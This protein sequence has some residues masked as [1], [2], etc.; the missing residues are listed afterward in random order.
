[1][2]TAN[3]PPLLTG[4]DPVSQLRLIK[5]YV[6]SPIQTI[7]DGFT[8]NG[9]VYAFQIMG[10]RQYTLRH[11][12]H[13]HQ[14]LVTDATKYHKDPVYKD[15]DKGLARFLGNG[16]LVSDGDFWKRQRKL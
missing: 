8:R 9:D 6:K 1:M 3:F 7:M 10:Q 2:T 13:I 12:D 11:P 16:L 4:T 5:T 15:S 14:V